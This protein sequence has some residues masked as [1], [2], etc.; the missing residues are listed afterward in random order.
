MNSAISF[1]SL[2]EWL[3]T[4]IKQMRPNDYATWIHQPVAALQNRS[5]AEVFQQGEVGKKE[6]REYITIVIGKFF[7]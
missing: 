7:S 1:D 6:L 5:V 2:P 3:R 4:P